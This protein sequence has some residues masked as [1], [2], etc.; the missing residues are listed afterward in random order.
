MLEAKYESLNT[1]W[2]ESE[3]LDWTAFQ[4]AI[5]GTMDLSNDEL[6]NLGSNL[7]GVG[8]FGGDYK[9]KEFMREGH[10]GFE[11]GDD[12]LE[13]WMGFKLGPVGG[14][15]TR[16]YS[17]WGGSASSGIL[18]LEADLTCGEMERDAKLLDVEGLNLPELWASPSLPPR[19]EERQK[20]KVEELERGDVR[21]EA[22]NE[23][24]WERPPPIPPRM[25]PRERRPRPFSF[26]LSP[27]GSGEFSVVSKGSGDYSVHSKDWS[28]SSVDSY[29]PHN[30]THQPTNHNS[31][32]STDKFMDDQPLATPTQTSY[33]KP[34]AIPTF[35]GSM[36]T[37]ASTASFPMSPM[38]Q[39]TGIESE[40]VMGSNLHHDLGDFLSWE[41]QFVPL[42]EEIE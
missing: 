34:M 35:A 1:V 8:D 32:N 11:D 3:P 13:W 9:G 17:P 33:A 41:S 6:L 24:D 19:S 25:R 2:E 21:S 22:E 42:G 26:Q 27:A 4:M 5:Q 37:P 36:D 12:Y 23:G 10:L 38:P 40:I 30:S 16:V 7:R 31:T 20:F 18:E 15:D 39:L 28:I 14:I 29:T